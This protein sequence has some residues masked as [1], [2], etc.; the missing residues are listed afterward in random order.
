MGVKSPDS[1]IGKTVIVTVR[2]AVIDSGLEQ[3]F[4]PD[5]AYLRKR[6]SELRF[7]SLLDTAYIARQIRREMN[8]PNGLKHRFPPNPDYLLKRWNELK[9]DSLFDSIYTSRLVN[10]ELKYA[11]G[12]FLDGLLNHRATICDTLVIRGVISGDGPGKRTATE[13][14]VPEDVARKFTGGIPLDDPTALMSMVTS[15]NLFGNDA[16]GNSKIYSRVTLDI[17]PGA[18]HK[19]IKDS[20]EAMGFSGFSYAEEFEEISKF[21]LYFHL[22]LSV[23]GLIALV[24]AA[25]GIINTLVMSILER[26]KEIGVM[27][28]LGADERDIRNLFLTESGV[29]GFTGSLIGILL[30]WGV[31]RIASYI[32][33]AY[34]ASEGISPVEL[35]RLPLWL[36]LAALAL[37]TLVSVI[38]G[39]YPASRAA[40][41]D[42][43]EALRSE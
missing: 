37:G 5:S 38:A 23:F 14:M 12:K 11:M 41:V 9:L 17:E 22:G 8:D 1:V 35:F 28:S 42:P 19:M 31:S 33:K 29:I 26:R 3:L 15:G 16:D 32:A 43:V 40:R 24:T 21:F 4:P 36:F 34:M 30:G 6:W 27:K 18:S 10:R 7:D 13:L 20:I 39:L 2:K 25:L